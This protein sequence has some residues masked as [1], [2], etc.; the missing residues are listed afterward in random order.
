MTVFYNVRVPVPK[1][2]VTVRHTHNC[3]VEYVLEQVYDKRKKTV[4]NRRTIIGY[5]CPDS[6]NMMFPNSKYRQIFPSEWSANSSEP[7]TPAYKKIGMYCA[8]RAIN[9]KE[10]IIDL[11]K[12]AFGNE[13]SDSILDFAMYSILYK[14]ATLSLFE[15]SMSEQMLFNKSPKSDSYYSNLFQ[16]G[17]S[18]SAIL[19]FKKSWALHCRTKGIDNVWLC[20]DGSNDDCTSQGVELAEKGHAKSHK[21]INIVSFSYAVT[22]SGLPVTFNVYRGGL[23]DAKA[24]K[25]ITDFLQ[26]C[27]IGIRGVILDRG[28]CSSKAVKFLNENGIPYIVIVKG[29]PLGAEQIVTEYGEAI[30]GNA[31]YFIEGTTLFG[32]QKPYQIFKDYK[33]LDYLTLFFDCANASD[34]ITT[35]MKKINREKSRLVS[36]L[37]TYKDKLLNYYSKVMKF[38]NDG[39]DIENTNLEKPELPKVADNL[40]EFLSIK[41]NTQSENNNSDESQDDEHVSSQYDVIINTQNFQNAINKKGLYSILSSE[42]LSPSDIDKLY[43]SRSSS[44]IQYKIFKTELGYGTT[45]IH[46]TSSLYSKFAVGFI[47]S[48]IRYQMQLHA[49]SI[50]QSTTNMIREMNMLSEIKINDVY[51]F[52]HIEN[53]RQLSFLEFFGCSE[54]LIDQCVK[55][56]NDRI[57]GRRPTPSY[58][59]PGPKP[60]DKTNENGSHAEMSSSGSNSGVSSVSPGDIDPGV[61][62][63]HE[64]SNGETG[65]PASTATQSS[66]DHSDIN[67]HHAVEHKKRGVKPGTKRGDFNKD[68]TP[69]KKPGVQVGTK[70]SPYKNDGN[71]RQKPGPKPRHSNIA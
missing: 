6:P 57:A 14:S 33:H 51:T 54:R 42:E 26:E 45:R 9:N 67:S 22:T 37:A 71:L 21:N 69:R 39:K 7:A 8:L 56:D 15:K 62:H 70:R 49:R 25:Q 48:I 23:V 44:E 66:N 29:S 34:R 47:S 55:E 11:V 17:I 4:D 40:K 24:M 63:S 53:K 52:S 68:G 5:V 27:N 1:E 58:R 60:K 38:I 10:R 12:E 19:K 50:D 36:A 32:V 31:S 65:I 35:L 18:Q 64:I 28:Y 61:Q 20:I 13:T 2:H 46:F 30:K 41:V 43:S 59:K 3:Q 16:K